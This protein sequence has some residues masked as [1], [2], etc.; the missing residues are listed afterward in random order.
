[1]P[2]S[3]PTLCGSIAGRPGRF[4]VAMHTAAYRAL[5]LDWTYVAFGTE[6]T[7]GAI[8]AVRALG[9][10]GL[11]VTMP[12]KLRVMSLVDV[13]DDT[14]QAIG[15]VNTIVNDDGVLTGHNVDW[16][17]AV[18]ALEEATPLDGRR[19]AVIGAGGGARSIV[20]GLRREGCR[21][22]VYNRSEQHGR[23]LAET[24]DAAWG[25]APSALTT[26]EDVEILAH[27][28]SV[29]FHAPDEML[30]A[31]D[32]LHPDLVVFDAVPTPPETRLLREARAR[33]CRTVPG[34]RMQ[35]HQA[36]E[37]FRLYTGRIADLDVMERALRDVMADM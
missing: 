18:R 27:A 29:G 12:H 37:Q 25:G 10:R 6:D 9:I 7:G 24:F 13:V 1:M 22:T 21:V 34:A 3:N 35:L 4:G 26:T 28:T 2:A 36:A 23:V 17:G 31:A 14:A 19:A 16:I 30:I 20:Y 33:G 5:G 11:G 32:V 8:A 15:A